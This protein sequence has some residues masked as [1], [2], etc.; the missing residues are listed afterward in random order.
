MVTTSSL[1]TEPSHGRPS[2]LVQ[3]QQTSRRVEDDAAAHDVDLRNDRS[4]EGDQCLPS[5]GQPK[6]QQVLG[7]AGMQADHLADLVATDGHGFE[8]DEIPF[9]PSVLVLIVFPVSY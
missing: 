7:G 5:V 9:V 3:V 1:M 8:P 2:Q 4:D 6:D